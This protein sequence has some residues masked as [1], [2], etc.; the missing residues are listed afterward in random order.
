MLAGLNLKRPADLLGPIG[1]DAQSQPV[2]TRSFGRKADAIVN[3][4]QNRLI[5][6]RGP[7]QDAHPMSPAMLHR[8]VDRLL[9][10]AKQMS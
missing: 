7:Q 2:S 8:V 1:H 4:S 9:R 3:D 5:A 6:A 10:E